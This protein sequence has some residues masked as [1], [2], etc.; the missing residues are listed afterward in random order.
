MYK[1]RGQAALEFLMTYGWAILS[2]IIVIGAL[3]SYFYFSQEG[4]SSIF[5][6][7]PF[8]GVAA[9]A[10]EDTVKLEIANKGGET[11]SSVTVNVTGQGCTQDTTNF[12]G[13]LSTPQIIT[14]TCTGADSGETFSGDIVVTYLRPGS[15]LP[16]TS[17]G[18]I[19]TPVA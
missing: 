19:S 9:S 1:K 3:G 5:V 8:Y 14:L 13:S 4:S 15:A 6:S 7:A 11:L 2:A 10:T 12:D 16:L 17:T 18:S